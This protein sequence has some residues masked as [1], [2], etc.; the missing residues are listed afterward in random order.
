MITW[1][2]Y[3]AGTKLK[4][5]ERY[6]SHRVEDILELRKHDIDSDYYTSTTIDRYTVYRVYNITQDTYEDHWWLCNAIGERIGSTKV[7]ILGRDVTKT[8]L[9]KLLKE[10]KDD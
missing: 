4:V 6:H 3:K 10:S 5:V 1:T 8:K 9:N 2:D 7:V